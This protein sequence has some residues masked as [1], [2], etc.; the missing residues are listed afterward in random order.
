MK[1]VTCIFL[2]FFLS[3]Y[4]FAGDGSE[5]GG[6]RYNSS[7][8]LQDLIQNKYFNCGLKF[9]YGMSKKSQSEKSSINFSVDIIVKVKPY[10]KTDVKN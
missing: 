4:A 9:N 8:D 10:I 1:K 5:G 6:D 3:T 7:I 2:L